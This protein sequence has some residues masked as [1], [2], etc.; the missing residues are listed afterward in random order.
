MKTPADVLAAVRQV[1]DEPGIKTEDAID[2]IAALVGLVEGRASYFFECLAF[3]AEK[4]HFGAK[5]FTRA[6]LLRAQEHGL[7]TPDKEQS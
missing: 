7:Y 3:E 2:R 1:L 4:P 5:E 6:L